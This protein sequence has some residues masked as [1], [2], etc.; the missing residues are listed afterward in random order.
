MQSKGVRIEAYDGGTLEDEIDN[1]VTENHGD[2]VACSFKF[3]FPCLL[4]DNIPSYT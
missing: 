3:A 2:E 4:Q 1:D